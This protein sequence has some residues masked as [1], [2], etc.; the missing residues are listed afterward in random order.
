[1]KNE[2]YCELV[3][4]TKKTIEIINQTNGKG[5]MEYIERIGKIENQIVTIMNMKNEMKT[6]IEEIKQT[7]SNSTVKQEIVI[8][9]NIVNK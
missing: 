5:F 7:K 1:M 6:E 3:E 2:L 4:E 9:D 8:P